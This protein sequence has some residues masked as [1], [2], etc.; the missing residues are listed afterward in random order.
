LTLRSRYRASWYIEPDIREAFSDEALDFWSSRIPNDEF[1]AHAPVKACLEMN[2]LEI[3]ASW[4]PGLVAITSITLESIG[5]PQAVL[6]MAVAGPIPDHLE[7]V[8]IK[9]EVLYAFELA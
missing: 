9:E 5:Y 8:R 1:V 6:E 2:G 3:A 7:V 4:S